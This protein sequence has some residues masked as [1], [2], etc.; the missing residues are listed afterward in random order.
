MM[1]KVEDTPTP[2]PPFSPL[3]AAMSVKDLFGRFSYEIPA[4]EALDGMP[5]SRLLILYGD[6]GSGKT[7]ILRMA[8]HLLSPAEQ[9]G[10]RTYL[11]RTPFSEFKIDLSDG[12]S[13]VARRH[14]ELVGSYQ[15]EVMRESQKILSI[16]F[17]VDEDN[18]IPRPRTREE[19]R[20]TLMLAS[21]L[22]DKRLTPYYLADDRSIYS[23]DIDDESGLQRESFN[24]IRGSQFL[25]SQGQWPPS[26]ARDF[27][28]ARRQWEL[29]EALEQVENL[30]R[31]RAFSGASTGHRTA[32]AIYLDVIQRLAHYGN[33]DATNAVES[34]RAGMLA[35]KIVAVGARNMQFEEF[36]LAEPVNYQELSRLVETAHS[37]R[38][39]LIAAVLVPHLEG[40]EARLDALA[41]VESE[42]RTFVS[43]MNAFLSH[44]SIQY[45]MFR[46]G[47]RINADNDEAISPSALSSGE[48]QLL[49]VM[50]RALVASE[51]SRLFII[52]E[53]ELSLN[54][55]WQRELLPA[56]LRC[57]GGSSM[58][59]LVATHSIEMVSEFLSDVTR[60]DT[61]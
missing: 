32:N 18:R 61:V 43:T 27:V 45:N 22:R 15:L 3:I 26:G 17:E 16:R 60:L 25:A 7:T 59:F 5:S 53:P 24:R 37:D 52:D 4:V 2:T 6:N 56:L 34:D 13:I 30:F 55:K 38:L 23:D 40:V 35:E 20:D 49:L 39:P 42:L 31:Q 8:Y 54:V 57:T 14:D 48:R 10:H 12:D 36:G 33:T 21:Y 50:C 58:Q 41:A 19:R 9:R 11:A 1:T 46:G 44:K 51:Q 47:L 29:D 28:E